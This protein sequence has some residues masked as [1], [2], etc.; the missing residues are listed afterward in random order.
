M[1]KSKEDVTPPV[2]TAQLDKD[3]QAALDRISQFLARRDGK[4]EKR[5]GR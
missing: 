1:E 2:S 4:P 3:A 5:A